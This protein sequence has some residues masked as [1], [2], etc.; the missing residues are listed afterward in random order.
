[1]GAHAGIGIRR[2]AA[3][4][5]T[6]PVCGA[7]VLENL[8]QRRSRT[9][10]AKLRLAGQKL[11][12][13]R[14]SRHHNPTHFCSSNC[15]VSASA[16]GWTHRASSSAQQGLQP[17]RAMEFVP[18]HQPAITP[19]ACTLCLASEPDQSV[20]SE[21]KGARLLWRLSAG[22]RP[23]A[24]SAR[25]PRQ[26][27]PLVGCLPHA[28][29]SPLRVPG[30]APLRGMIPVNTSRCPQRGHRSGWASP[31]WAQYSCHPISSGSSTG[32]CVISTI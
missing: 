25:V 21:S 3:S 22:L 1:M 9:F 30:G 7:L 13:G 29:R 26:T 28:A 12:D 6:D 10:R 20:V 11:T 17:H 14:N 32:P 15:Q 31:R 16:T 5:E 19:L 2:N 4:T 23:L 24:H 18:D 8:T 27:N